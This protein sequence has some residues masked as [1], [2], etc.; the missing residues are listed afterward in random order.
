MFGMI[1]LKLVVGLLGLLLVVRLIGKK[2]LSEI[3]PFDLIYT[4]V[5]GGILEE[6]LYD[7]K[8]NIG[9]LLLA[10]ALWALMIYIIE[11]VV[12][13][14]E[15]INRWIKG[16]AAVLVKNGVLNLKEI[17]KNHIEMEQLREMLRQAECFS[18]EN[19]KHVVLENAGQISVLKESED[20]K[21]MTILLVDQGNIQKKVLQ[22]HG[23][24][25]SW[26]REKLKEEGHT[27]LEDIVYVEWSEERGFYVVTKSETEHRIYR[28]DG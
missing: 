18:L 1:A 20:N 11:Q 13:K 12:Q 24:K 19:A 22:T 6:S 10:L 2:S 16:E 28:I 5:L 7:D 8:V 3:T 23:L 21:V 15:R 26:L 17:S 25:E 14:N 4:L 9:H 27:N